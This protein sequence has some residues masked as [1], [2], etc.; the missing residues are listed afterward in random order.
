MN[1]RLP[2]L[3]SAI[4]LSSCTTQTYIAPT[5]TQVSSA[6][7]TPIALQ[8]NVDQPLQK[9]GKTCSPMTNE[10]ISPSNSKT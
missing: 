8:R 7:E 5:S 9:H 6:S 3:G 4:V 10:T 2:V 1:H